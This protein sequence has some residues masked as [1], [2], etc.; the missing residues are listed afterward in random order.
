MFLHPFGLLAIAALPAIAA[1]YYFRRRF[2]PK[3]VSAVFLWQVRDR[4]PAAGRKFEKLRNSLSFWLELLASLLLTF[5]IAGFRGCGERAVHW[6]AVLDGSASMGAKSGNINIK[7]RAVAAVRERIAALASNANVTILTTGPAPAV[8]A[9]PRALPGEALEKLNQYFP[10]LPAHDTNT[11]IALALQ[12]AG[13]NS[14]TFITDHFEPDAFPENVD[15]VAVGEALDNLGFT[16]VAR[17]P[18]KAFFTIGN[19]T[20]KAASANFSILAFGK[21]ILTK[22]IDLLALE[23]KSLA[24]DLPKDAPAVEAVLDSDALDLDNH[25]FL[26]PPPSRTVSIFVNTTF[27]A[28]ECAA[29]GFSNGDKSSRADKLLAIVADAKE[30]ADAAAAQLLI[31]RNTVGAGDA[32]CLQIGAPGEERKDWIGPYLLDK[33]HPLLEGVTLEGVLWSADP[34][35]KIS[36]YTI[37]SA[38]N[39][40][41]ITETREGSRRIY[42]LNFDPARSTLTKTPD[43]PILLANL[44]EARRTEL[45]GALAT[46]LRIGET[47]LYRTTAEGK[48]KIEGGGISR[49]FS[50]RELL[51]I[52]APGRPGIFKLKKVAESEKTKDEILGEFAVNFFDAAESDLT[53]ASSGARAACGTQAESPAEIANADVLLI[54][55]ALGCLLL[56]WYILARSARRGIYS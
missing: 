55:G 22:K 30:A 19:F 4:V 25:A 14:I 36:G 2:H 11:A 56:D 21:S 32:W 42:K 31:S 10:A 29:L 8:L 44:V 50:G 53:K 40:P 1:V 5:A 34:N 12:F 51:S 35:Y 24:V 9:G 41:L 15:V 18:E 7:E 39:Q 33:R 38:G 46:N 28:K 45:P 52:D 49:E 54:F 17:T 43:W 47:F 37:A 23:R 27:S 48:F 26:A 6:V 13:G 3:I 20:N 16:H